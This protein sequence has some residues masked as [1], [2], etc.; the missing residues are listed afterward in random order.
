MLREEYRLSRLAKILPA[1]FLTLNEVNL[2]TPLHKGKL[3]PVVDF[4]NV[5]SKAFT[6]PDPKSAKIQSSHQF[7]RPLGSTSVKTAHKK[8]M[9]L[10]PDRDRHF[11]TFKHFF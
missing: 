1:I 3:K 9:K 8:L 5:L 10:T 2:F 11:F 7:F 4:I 6:R